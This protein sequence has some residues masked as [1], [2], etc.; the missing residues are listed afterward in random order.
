MPE[1]PQQNIVETLLMSIN[2]AHDQMAYKKKLKTR[3]HQYDQKP[4]DKAKDNHI[5]LINL[6]EKFLCKANK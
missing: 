2:S 3:L 1:V 4:C 5:F 6:M